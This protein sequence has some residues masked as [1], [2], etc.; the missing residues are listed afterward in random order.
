M[1][2]RLLF[3][4]ALLLAMGSVYAG[5][6]DFPRWVQW[7]LAAAAIITAIVGSRAPDEPGGGERE[8]DQHRDQGGTSSRQP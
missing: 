1:T 7:T 4:L 6:F 3:G 8:R 5:L 2:R